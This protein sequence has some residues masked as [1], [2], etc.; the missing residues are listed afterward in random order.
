M[1]APVIILKLDG[2]TMID[3]DRCRRIIAALFQ[4]GVFNVRGGDAKLNFDKDGEIGSIKVDETRWIRD[5]EIIPLQN[6]L[7]L[8]SIE[9]QT[10]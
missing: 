9:M 4:G 3:A 7:P 2:A 5:K 1:Q 8:V 6:K 10:K